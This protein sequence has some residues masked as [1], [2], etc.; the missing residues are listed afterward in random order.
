MKKEKLLNFALTLNRKNLI[1][2]SLPFMVFFLVFCFTVPAFPRQITP[3]QGSQMLW[4]GTVDGNRDEVNDF[5][6]EYE[7]G[8]NISTFNTFGGSDHIPF[9]EYGYDAVFFHEH[10]FNDYYHSSND[11]IENMDIEYDVKVTKLIVGT[12]LN[13]GEVEEDNIPPEVSLEKPKEY[14]YIAGKEI[15]PIMPARPVTGIFAML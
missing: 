9:L 2:L 8:L 6:N 7:I 1:K 14:L 4:I 15:L 10:E 11:T 5:T 13:I 12:L 3:P